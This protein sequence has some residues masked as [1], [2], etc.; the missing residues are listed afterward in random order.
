MDLGKVIYAIAL[1][2][3]YDNCGIIP[4]EALDEY[5]DRLE[6]RI[7][8]FPESAAILGTP[9]LNTLETPCKARPR[10]VRLSLLYQ[11]IQQWL[12]HFHKVIC[13]GFPYKS[14]VL[15]RRNRKTISF[16]S[17]FPLSRYSNA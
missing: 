12:L 6:E 8:K 11:T 16:L 5:K 15:H 9:R 13:A 7:A 1:E 14:N 2:C 4:L 17:S 10:A 3:G